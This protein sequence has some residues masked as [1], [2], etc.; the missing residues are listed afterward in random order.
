ML[1]PLQ[2]TDRFYNGYPE[3]H[4]CNTIEKSLI[5][6]ESSIDR[7]WRKVDTKMNTMLRRKRRVNKWELDMEYIVTVRGLVSFWQFLAI[8]FHAR[9]NSNFINDKILFIKKFHKTLGK[10]PWNLQKFYESYDDGHD[11]CNVV[12]IFNHSE[13]YYLSWFYVW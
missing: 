10:S 13:L 12:R 11:L 3:V 5:E 7:M 1:L 8:P 9:R 2:L 4:Y 6:N